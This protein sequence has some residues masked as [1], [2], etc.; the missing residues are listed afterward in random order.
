MAFGDYLNDYE[1]LLN[2]TESYCMENGH[3]KLKAIAKYTAPSNDEDGV[4]AILRR[5]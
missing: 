4:M 5:L 3:P 2:C 1:L